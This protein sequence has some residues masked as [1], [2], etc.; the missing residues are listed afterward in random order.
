[1]ISKE[2]LLKMRQ[3][4]SNARKNSNEKSDDHRVGAAILGSSGKIYGGCCLL[5]IPQD[6]CAERVALFKAISEGEKKI[7]AVL[8]TRNKKREGSEGSPCG[9]CLQALWAL[10]NNPN[11]LI[12]SWHENQ[13]EPFEPYEIKYFYPHPYSPKI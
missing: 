9:H 7:E 8:I 4:A 3:V 5:S 11:L 1:M 2:T 13:E 12:Y 6:Y 10:S